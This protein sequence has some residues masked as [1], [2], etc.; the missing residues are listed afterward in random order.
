ME[1]LLQDFENGDII[2]RDFNQMLN[3]WSQKGNSKFYKNKVLDNVVLEFTPSLL[4]LLV[5]N[6]SSYIISMSEK[7]LEDE[8][9]NRPNDPL[10][11]DFKDYT[12]KTLDMDKY[13]IKKVP[14]DDEKMFHQIRNVL[15]HSNYKL[16]YDYEKLNDSYIE[17]ENDS[18][19]GRIPVTVLEQMSNKYES[20]VTAMMEDST[21]LC[22]YK[23]LTNL[24]STNEKSF[25]EALHNIKKGEIVGRSY[26]STKNY[27]IPDLNDT[28]LNVTASKLS[29]EERRVLESYINYIGLST[30]ND[31]PSAL[32]H[33]LLLLVSKI[34]FSSKPYFSKNFIQESINTIMAPKNYPFIQLLSPFIYQNLLIQYTHYCFNTIKELA[35]KNTID[36]SLYSNVDL[37]DVDI[38]SLFDFNDSSV[39]NDKIN[40]LESGL[41]RAKQDLENVEKQIINIPKSTKLTE[42]QKTALLASR[43][44]Y[45]NTKNNDISQ[46]TLEKS[47]LENELN[48][49]TQYLKSPEFYD[50]LRNSIS[51]G[52]IKIDYLSG[53]DYRNLGNT[54][55]T[56]YDK[57]DKRDVFEFKITSKNLQLLFNNLMTEVKKQTNYYQQDAEVNAYI[58]NANK[59]ITND[60]A[61]EVTSQLINEDLTNT[62]FKLNDIS[63]I[64]E[65]KKTR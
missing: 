28:T 35:K 15:A 42:E 17:C 1:R 29:N 61:K 56:F 18:I 59:N 32:N 34:L 46:M 58:I 3:Y 54:V 40:S 4:P 53:L 62:K 48:N 30:W 20:V 39:L 45:V 21:I 41:N 12:L 38:I 10:I 51:H 25:Q 44:A 33:N 2:I 24:T 6:A 37:S 9:A 60:S 65:K 55:I 47:S 64:N 63:I 36:D 57:N 5:V 27:G 50:K 13:F 8:I 19:K 31:M 22:D 16:Y 43:Q 26:S 14:L 49:H 52:F 7:R 23:N 11:Q